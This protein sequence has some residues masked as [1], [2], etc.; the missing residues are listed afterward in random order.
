MGGWEGNAMPPRDA[1]PLAAAAARRALELDETL[2]EAHTSLAHVH[3]HYDWDWRAAQAEFRRAVEIHPSYSTAHHWLS[4]LAMAMGRPEVSLAES[5]RCLQLDPVDLILNVHLIWHYWLAGQPDEAIEQGVKTGELYPNS[6]WPQFFSGL[7]FEEKQM[8]DAAVAH[9]ER[10][11][12]MSG[13]TAFVLAALGHS[14]AGAGQSGKAVEL[15]RRLDG[16][17]R[18]R[19]VPAYDRA[20]IYLGLNELDPAMEW[21][22]RAYGERSSWITYLNVEPRLA[23]LRGDSRFTELASGLG[24]PTAATQPTRSR[25]G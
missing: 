11:A 6:F 3:L 9:L 19:Y 4:H 15:L 5:R 24:Y 18:E 14:Y 1:W 17:S 13:G 2:G 21:L 20:I 7:A 16:L 12:E 23:P 8:P 25:S 22:Q 10:A